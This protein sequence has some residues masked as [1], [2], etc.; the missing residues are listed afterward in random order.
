[1]SIKKNLSLGVEIMLLM[2]SLM[3]S[4]LA[5]GVPASKGKCTLSPPATNIVQFGSYV[6]GGLM[7]QVMRPYVTS[8]ALAFGTLSFGMNKIVSIP[9]TGPGTPCV[10]H[11]SLLP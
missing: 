8:F 1:M 2:S 11:P 9:V 3:V 7:R 6:F 10:S 4:K 5:V